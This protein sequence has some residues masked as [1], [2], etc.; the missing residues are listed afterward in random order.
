MQLKGKILVTGGSGF[1]GRV[2]MMSAIEADWD[3][4][5]IVYSRDEQKQDAIRRRFPDARLVLGDIRDTER[6][7]LAMA[8]ADYVLHAGAL[9]YIP[10][11]E[12]NVNECYE[13]N[14]GGSVSVIRA[15]RAAGV[16]TVLAVSTDKAVMPLNV[17]GATKMLM[18]RLFVEADRQ[19][20]PTRFG[21]VRYGNVIGSTGSIIPLWQQQAREQKIVTITEPTMTRFWMAPHEAVDLVLHAFHRLEYYDDRGEIVVQKAAAM[22]LMELFDALRLN[23]DH[24]F[25]GRRPGE[26]FDE[27]LLSEYEAAKAT[28]V[29]G[30]YVRFAPLGPADSGWD[31]VTAYTSGKPD[32]WLTADA[33]AAAVEEA[34]GV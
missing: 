14:V 30:Q 2:T 31:T 10:E 7:A 23:V 6:L 3:A 11:A 33:L 8:G 29:D 28:G 9:K 26:K 16:P 20:G 17:Y 32:R 22:N 34:A 12:F 27:T 25:I 5:F 18:E 13:I 19:A 21:V 1:L 4:Q 15:A 24:T